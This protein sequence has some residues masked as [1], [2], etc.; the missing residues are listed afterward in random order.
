MPAWDRTHDWVLERLWNDRTRVAIQFRQAPP[1]V[2]ELAAVRRCLPQFQHMAPAVARAVIGDSGVLSLGD[3]PSPEARQLIE[4]AE[5]QGLRVV[6]E[7][8][9]FV[10]YLPFDR[11]TGCAWLIEADAEATAAAQ[12]MLAAGAP[13]RGE[14]EA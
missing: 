5:A 10:S 11:T 3:L 14:V 12:A 9:P 2:A 6:A 7:G 1:S 13:V 8:A 4:A